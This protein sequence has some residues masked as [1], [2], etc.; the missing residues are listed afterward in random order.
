[1]GSI[2]NS[3]RR[4][5]GPSDETEANFRGQG[6]IL[7]GSGGVV[8]LYCM[9]IGEFLERDLTRDRGSFGDNFFLLAVSKWNFG[10]GF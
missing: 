4:E 3:R 9:G 2:T 7:G 6:W 1:M 10:E 5:T 8:D